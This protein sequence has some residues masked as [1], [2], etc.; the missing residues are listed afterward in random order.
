MPTKPGVREDRFIL[1]SGKHMGCDCTKPHHRAPH[2]SLTTVPHSLP[3]SSLLQHT[4]FLPI[5]PEAAKFVLLS[6][7]Q[8]LAKHH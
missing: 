4:L 1:T 7:L 8:Y 6:S 5:S 2:L 3:G